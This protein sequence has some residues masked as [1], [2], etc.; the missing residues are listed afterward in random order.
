[1][2]DLEMGLYRSE[3]RLPKARRGYVAFAKQSVGRAECSRVTTFQAKGLGQS[4]VDGA[5]AS[6]SHA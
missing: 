2:D 4:S 5:T 3:P 6:T 1:M